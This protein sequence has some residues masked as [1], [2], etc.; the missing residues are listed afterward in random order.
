MEF[1]DKQ[2]LKTSTWDS[3][4]MRNYLRRLGYT[5]KLILIVWITVN[6]K[7]ESDNHKS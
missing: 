3:R 4:Y 1:I 7:V 6:R 2:Y 5:G